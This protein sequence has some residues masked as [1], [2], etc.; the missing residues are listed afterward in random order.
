M[1]V[2]H[3]Y[4][5]ILIQIYRKQ[6]DLIDVCGGCGCIQKRR[7]LNVTYTKLFVVNLIK[8]SART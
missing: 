2:Q 7:R 6:Y 5:H 1:Y 4:T 3:V 8:N